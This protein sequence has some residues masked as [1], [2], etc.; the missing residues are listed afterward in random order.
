[1]SPFQD[2]L[3][4]INSKLDL[5]QPTRS[6]ILLEIAGDLDDLYSHFLA[7]HQDEDRARRE[8][9]ARLDL[10]EDALQEMVR[11][12][13]GGFRLWL[14]RLGAQRLS[15]WEKGL[16][17]AVLIF[18]VLFTGRLVA[19]GSIFGLAGPFVWP[20]ILATVA[21]LMIALGK[22]YHLNLKKD[23]RPGSLRWGLPLL[24]GLSLTDLLVGFIGFWFG[25]RQASGAIVQDT[26][27]TL[28]YL[29]HW[30]LGG[31]ALLII[32]FFGAITIA[33]LWFNLNWRVM[34]IEA[35]E[36]AHLLGAKPVVSPHTFT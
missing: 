27:Q 28:V 16:F 19:T 1:M 7:Q 12:H 26:D 4:N 34:D 6:R 21:G 23:H 13:T 9:A 29:T 11:I 15:R 20:V 32:A 10:S 3:S 30:L 25:L 5:P 24:M 18:V 17:L 35:A 33:L 14:D 2:L 36:T 22:H 31:S 8:A